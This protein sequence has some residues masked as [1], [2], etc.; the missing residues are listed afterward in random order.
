MQDTQARLS[1][2]ISVLGD[3]P[4]LAELK[5]LLSKVRV[6]MLVGHT[7]T[8]LTPVLLLLERY[9]FEVLTKFAGN[10]RPPV[11]LQDCLIGLGM[12]SIGSEGHLDETYQ[13]RL[14]R[15]R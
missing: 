5:G 8:D 3:D 12:M 6:A 9:E 10:V 14:G 11:S 4:Q 15:K 1:A 13:N 2:A 7:P